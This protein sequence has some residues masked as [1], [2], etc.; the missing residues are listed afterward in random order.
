MK[1]LSILLS[2]VLASSIILAACGPSKESTEEPASTQPGGIPA[3]TEPAGSPEVTMPAETS[4]VTETVSTPE[5]TTAPVITP[6]IETTMPVTGTEVIP[7][8]GFVD[9]GRV[10][11]LLDF[12]VYDQSDK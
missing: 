1:K 6:T 9:P 11:N 12:A 3:V 10:S 2:L 8:T 7:S 5:V 4:Q